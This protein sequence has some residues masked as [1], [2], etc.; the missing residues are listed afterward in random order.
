MPR[1][2]S[3]LHVRAM[4][5]GAAATPSARRAERRALRQHAVAAAL[6]EPVVAMPAPDPRHWDDL[7]VLAARLHEVANAGVEPASRI[8]RDAIEHGPGTVPLRAAYQ[9][10]RAHA[11]WIVRAR[12]TGVSRDDLARA[13]Q[14]ARD[15]FELVDELATRIADDA[16]TAPLIA[17]ARHA[18]GR[19]H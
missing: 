18:L 10:G 15:A 4:A 2:H 12:G 16:T 6:A 8:Y 14:L 7:F 1:A 17:S 11:R 13:A 9:L 5:T 19:S 3:L